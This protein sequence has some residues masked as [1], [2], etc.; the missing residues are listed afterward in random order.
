MHLETRPLPSPFRPAEHACR[1]RTLPTGSLLHAARAAVEANPHNAPHSGSMPLEKIELAMLTTKRWPATGV[2]LSVQFL[3]N[4]PQEVRQKILAYANSWQ[5][6]GRVKVRFRETG[7]QGDVRILRDPSQGYNSY[8]GTDI[9][10]VPAGEETMNL[11]NFTE[12]LPDAEY[13]RVVPHEFGHTLG[14]PH[15]HLRFAIIS[16]LDPARTIAYFAE[17]YGWS[18]EMTTQQVLTPVAESSLFRTSSPADVESIMCY[19]LPGACTKS[20]QPVLGG[21][22][23]D[24]LD[25]ATAASFYPGTVTPPPPPD[26]GFVKKLKTTGT[27]AF[28]K[29]S[30]GRIKLVFN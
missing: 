19:Q 5:D 22:Q 3:D 29:T 14:F 30:D 17:H 11:A 26:D 18:A 2:D 25:F 4:P 24:P 13:M 28:D 9:R 15:E 1:L 6:G 20:G 27:Y 8:L 10:V 16:L 7:Q 23:I 21:T 12:S